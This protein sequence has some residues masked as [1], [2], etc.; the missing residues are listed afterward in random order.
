MK[1]FLVKCK[2]GHVGRNKYLPLIVPVKAESAKE[3][4][5]LA[6]RVNGIKKDHKDWCLEEPIEV[7]DEKYEIAK[8]VFYSDVYFEKKSRS[9]TYL[10]KGRLMD[11][12]NYSRINGV[13]T[14]K[15]VYTKKRTKENIEYK[16][17]KERI[18]AESFLSEQL[19][20]LIGLQFNA[21]RYN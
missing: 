8:N 14:N 5:E 13:K 10:F 9:R 1:N 4:S 19:N 7:D 3:A 6:K 12:A 21:R 20:S 15:K 17:K 2:F 16:C 11:E 18:F